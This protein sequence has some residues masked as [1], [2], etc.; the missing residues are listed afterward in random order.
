MPQSKLSFFH[1]GAALLISAIASVCDA[2]Y[3]QKNSNCFIPTM[4]PLDV[5]AACD[6]N[7]ASDPVDAQVYQARGAAWYRQGDYDHAIADF[8]KSISI[9]SKY[10]RAFYNRGLA[11]EKKGKL[12]EA[13]TDFRYFADLDPSFP[14]VHKAIERAS[15]AKKRIEAAAI[16]PPKLKTLSFVTR[17]THR[18]S[19]AFQTS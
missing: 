15:G 4:P 19:R 11:W 18:L 16:K 9:D 2:A 14:D 17:R 1:V 5:I 12:D 3:A 13:L 6:Q 7:I 10:I 8:S